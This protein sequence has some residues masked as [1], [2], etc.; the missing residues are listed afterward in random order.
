MAWCR[1]LSDEN[2]FDD[3]VYS[4]FAGKILNENYVSEV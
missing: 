2:K 4:T 3:K 1:V